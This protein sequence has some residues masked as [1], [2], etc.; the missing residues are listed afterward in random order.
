MVVT[1]KVELAFSPEGTE[2]L[3]GFKCG[4]IPV[5]GEA[6]AVRLTVPENPLMLATVMIA[7]PHASG[8]IS[9]Q[10]ELTEKS[11]L[12]PNA[13]PMTEMPRTASTS[14]GTTK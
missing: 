2:T 12:C 5:L 1:V 14:N 10:F 3:V 8:A 13:S 6:V 7:E 9:S 4:V 11:G